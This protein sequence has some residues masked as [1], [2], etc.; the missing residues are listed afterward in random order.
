VYSPITFGQKY[1]KSGE[2]VR[3]FLPVLKVCSRPSSPLLGAS[4]F[5]W[6]ILLI[7]H[8][9]GIVTSFL[10]ADLA[11]LTYIVGCRICQISTSTP[12]G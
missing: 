5:M 11:G 6:G 4:D 10:S 1:D 3:N 12:H 8:F 2:Y 7:F 9:K